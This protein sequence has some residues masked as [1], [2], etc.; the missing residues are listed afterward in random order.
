MLSL[1]PP[2]LSGASGRLPFRQVLPTQPRVCLNGDAGSPCARAF[3]LAP[4]LPASRVK[5]ASSGKSEKAWIE[6]PYCKS[7]ASTFKAFCGRLRHRPSAGCHWQRHG[8]RV[9]TLPAGGKSGDHETKMAMAFCTA[10]LGVC[11][12]GGGE[13]FA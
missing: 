2:P 7:Q 13:A 11:L 8:L 3:L 9:S 1:L 10:A 6:I 12:C 5:S 4:P